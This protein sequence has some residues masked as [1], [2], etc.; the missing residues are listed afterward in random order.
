[1]LKVSIGAVQHVWSMLKVSIGAV[2]HVW[3]MLKVSI[4]AVQH[5]WRMLKVSIGAVQHV[6]RML[7]F[8]IGA[9]Q[10]VWR[11]LKDAGLNY[12]ET[13][14]LNQDL[15]ANTFVVILLHRVSFNNPTLGQFVDALK[16]SIINGLDF[17]DLRNTNCRDD[18]LSFWTCYIHS[19][20]NLMFLYHIHPQIMVL[21]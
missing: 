20:W 13:Q 6:W 17:R 14:N 7:K 8:S 10:H 18:I 2:Q 4:G 19:K 16:T 9:V 21:E 1:M 15:L 3:R 11:M 12:L 5:V